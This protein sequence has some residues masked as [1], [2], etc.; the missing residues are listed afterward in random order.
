MEIGLVSCTKA[1]A[2]SA[3]TPRE[4]YNPSAL[5]RKARKYVEENHDEWYVLSAKHHVLDPDGSP[6]EPYD[7]T[8]NNAGVEERREWSQ[9]VVEQLREHSL[10]AAENTLV[11]HTG[12]SYYET[13]LPLLNDEPVDVEIPTEGLRMGETLSWY[14]E[15]I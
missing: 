13:L 10:L 5:F 12:K 8:L 15:R 1:K 11:I 3:S 4:L 7:E 9:T 2:D 6:I 14:N